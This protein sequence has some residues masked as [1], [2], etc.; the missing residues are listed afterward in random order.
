MT[1]SFHI[2][3]EVTPA[4]LKEVLFA[5]VNDEPYDYVTQ[6]DRQVTR[7][8]QLGLLAGESVTDFGRNIYQL[9]QYNTDLWGG[10]LHF[11]HYTRWDNLYPSQHG[12]S[13]LYRQFVDQLWEDR[14]VQLSREYLDPLVASLSNEA[15]TNPHF[16]PA[17]LRK[18]VVSLSRDSLKGGMHCLDA[19]NPT[20][21]TSK[22]F[23]R[24]HYC[25]PEV[26]LLALGWVAKQ[27]DGSLG[28]DWLL[29]PQRRIAICRLCLLEPTALDQILDWTLPTYANVIVPGTSAGTYGRFVRFLQWPT[30]T[31]LLP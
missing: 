22:Q 24:R 2:R 8:R 26:A 3:H 15:D 27:D 16:D 31:H 20:V 5:L 28:I 18:A 25:T 1:L 23:Q 11:I 17:Q 4:R 29:T 19:L 30:I 6:A 10:L 9:C 12:F 13:W 21:I 14:S 7:L